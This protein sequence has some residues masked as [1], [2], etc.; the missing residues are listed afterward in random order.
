MND[1]MKTVQA[2]EDSNVCLKGVSK[3]IENETKEQKGGFL[4]MLLGTLGAS[5]LGNILSGK[6]T[7][8]AGEGIIRAGYGS[9]IKKIALMS[10]DLLTNFEI[11]EY[12]EKDPRFNGVYSRDNLPKTI[13][14]G[15]YVINL[16]EYADIGTHWIALYVKNNEV[17]YFDS[18][19]VEHVPKEIKRFIGHKSTKTNIFR[20]QVDNSIMSRYFCI[21]F[22]DFM[23]AGKSLINFTSVFS[24]FD[25][26]KN[27]RIILDYFK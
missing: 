20:M 23:F 16:D 3:T 13:K 26:K 18:F 7:V 12:Y 21:G 6:E 22:I 19:G 14:N 8:R 15:A 5:L 24:P 1:I 9:S 11:K 4:S 17:I 2:L 10:P 27:N 25:F